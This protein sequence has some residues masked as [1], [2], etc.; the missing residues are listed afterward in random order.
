MRTLGREQMVE[1]VKDL[2]DLVDADT[3][4]EVFCEADGLL[5]AHAGPEVAQLDSLREALA[6]AEG[7]IVLWGGFGSRLADRLTDAGYEEAIEVAVALKPDGVDDE[8][9]MCIT[10]LRDEGQLVLLKAKIDG[11]GCLELVELGL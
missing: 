9:A 3:E 5:A 1:M 10:R 11:K 7:D 6:L 8:E 2:G 4:Q